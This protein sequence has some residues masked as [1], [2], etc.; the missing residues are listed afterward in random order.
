MSKAQNNKIL[1][2]SSS[3]RPSE[4]L[5]SRLFLNGN[6]NSQTPREHIFI[7]EIFAP[8][9]D[10]IND[11][12]S[13]KWRTI[14]KNFGKT[15]A[16]SLK[17]NGI[18]ILFLLIAYFTA[19]FSTYT[20]ERGLDYF[21]IVQMLLITIRQL[22]LL[23]K[24]KEVIFLVP[25][26]FTTIMWFWVAIAHASRN[27]MIFMATF[28]GSQIFFVIFEFAIYGMKYDISQLPV[29]LGI[30]FNIL[31]WFS[32]FVP[33]LLP[34]NIAILWIYL[35]VL[36]VF[37][38]FTELVTLV[39]YGYIP[40]VCKRIFRGLKQGYIIISK[41][42]TRISN[43]F[44]MIKLR[45]NAGSFIKNFKLKFSKVKTHRSLT[46]Y[47]SP[48]KILGSILKICISVGIIV[49]PFLL[50][51]FFIEFTY[52]VLTNIPIIEVLLFTMVLF[53]YTSTK[54]LSY[55]HYFYLIFVPILLGWFAQ[56]LVPI[57]IKFYIVPCA[58]IPSYF[59]LRRLPKYMNEKDKI[60]DS[61]WP[62]L[63][64]FSL[65]NFYHTY[66]YRL[67]T[68]ILILLG[69]VFCIYFIFYPL[70]LYIPA[71]FFILAFL[72][73]TRGEHTK[74]AKAI[75]KTGLI[76]LFLV[77]MPLIFTVNNMIILNNPTYQWAQ[78]PQESRVTATR[79]DYNTLQYYDSLEEFNQFTINDAFLS[80]CEISTSLGQSAG[81]EYNLI[82]I[83]VPKVEGYFAKDRYITTTDSI[84]G[85]LSSYNLIGKV[86]LDQLDLLPGL[87]EISTIYNVL[88]GFGRRYAVP[89]VYEIT[90]VRDSLE[91]ISE[92]E[93]DVDVEY[94][95]VYT[96]KN[97]RSWSIIFDGQ[98]I[99]SLNE[100]IPLQNVE[101]FIEVNDRWNK[102][103]TLDTDAKGRF[104]YN[105]TVYGSIEQNLLVKVEHE[106]TEF[107]KPLEHIEYAGIEWKTDN[108]FYFTQDEYGSIKWPFTLYDLLE[109]LASSAQSPT[110]S[111]LDFMAEFDESTGTSVYDRIHNYEGTLQG[112]TSWTTGKRDY[113]LLF[114]GDDTV[115]FGD[116]LD[117]ALGSSNDKFVI[118][119]W[120]RPTAFLSNQS[121]NG[122]QNCF[123]SKYGIIEA[124]VNQSGYVQ[125]YLNTNSV[126]TTATYGWPYAIPLNTWTYLA[127]RY[128]QSDVDILIGDVWCTSALGGVNEPWDGG[129]VLKS[130]GDVIIG[131][132]PTSYSCFTGKL[133]DISVFNSSVSNA[134]IESHSNGPVIEINVTVSKEDGL[135]GWTSIPTNGELIEGYLNFIC[136]STGKPIESLEFYLSDTEPDL[137]DP[138]PIEWN[139]LTSFDYD[140]SH[141]SYV[142]DSWDLPDDQTWYFVVKAVDDINNV[143]YD[144]YS[145]YFGIEHFNELVNFTY[146]DKS[147]RINHNSEIGVTPIEG[148]EWHISSLNV[149][150]NYSN[151]I[152]FLIGVDYNDL[153]SNYW[154]IYLDSL[155]DWVSSK[156]LTP[157]IYDVNFIIEAN[158]T[159]GTNFPF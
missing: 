71:G 28:L 57:F 42:F 33:P 48:K 3:Q 64:T 9:M 10:S 72:L 93:L 19:P 39:V 38:L 150:I 105:H 1:E 108:K 36:L 96:I 120:I 53:L 84:T 88:D 4:E 30:M 86:Q 44:Y 126:E 119:A 140:D 106:G 114:D 5:Y 21:I 102:V 112:N 113:G 115:N 52:V 55:L 111:S 133:D 6:I 109:V 61:R 49:Y 65:S 79:I 97:K 83:D 124:G 100:P 91:L 153:C 66:K 62:K 58:V 14:M 152:D 77:L 74:R 121:D 146:I 151:D 46:Y 22:V 67:L 94:G 60:R 143:V 101:L 139:L 85:P 141:Y 41:G 128:N 122:V 32:F 18:I 136:N 95:A 27:P 15:V 2:L 78:I 145:I 47:V 76:S 154:L 31:F 159:F 45:T 81:L 158:L 37:F 63:K 69:V 144:S 157:D 156:G 54:R 70:L 104:Y 129:G 118:S 29:K 134:E 13:S 142:N 135:G 43:S 90:I 127:V 35:I 12:K 147:G 131:A 123:L 125:I 34:F 25:F 8:N 149:Y 40:R 16:N 23:K 103:T 107:Y 59:I 11:R 130:G 89:E 87:Y 17:I 26:I 24:R 137:Q 98:I 68:R 99:N 117:N 50:R 148:C 138:N 82:P 132:E 116:I 155:S 51:L 56:S 80:R 7:E 20:V 73:F 92:S 110:P 75:R